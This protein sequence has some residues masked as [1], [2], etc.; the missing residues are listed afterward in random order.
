MAKKLILDNE[1]N[2]EIDITGVTSFDVKS[3]E[4]SIRWT[5]RAVIGTTSA[6]NLITYD[7]FQEAAF[8]RQSL[9]DHVIRDDVDTVIVDEETGSI[10]PQ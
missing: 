7:T 2:T 9:H 3:Q 6:T 1:E 8:A 10:V 5:V 4:G